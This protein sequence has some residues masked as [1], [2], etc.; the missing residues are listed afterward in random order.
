[1]KMGVSGRLLPDA[2]GQVDALTPFISKL[3]PILDRFVPFPS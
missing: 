2:L 3:L 1:M